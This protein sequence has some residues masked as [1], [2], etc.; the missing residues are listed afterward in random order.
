MKQEFSLA[1]QLHQTPIEKRMLVHVW[2]LPVMKGTKFA[3]H[4]CL[5]YPRELI[6]NRRR[7]LERRGELP[8][9]KFRNR[10]WRRMNAAYVFKKDM[11]WDM[12]EMH[13]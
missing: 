8:L 12:P 6:R 7:I 10:T 5:F 3:R 11:T 13:R 1:C 2:L 9:L 4:N